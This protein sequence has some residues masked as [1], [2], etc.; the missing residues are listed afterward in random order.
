MITRT[1]RRQKIA[2]PADV[3]S[4][5]RNP[6]VRPVVEYGLWGLG[7]WIASA[8]HQQPIYYI[9]LL[10]VFLNDLRNISEKRKGLLRDVVSGT[11][12]ALLGWALS[13]SV[14]RVLGAVVAI[15]AFLTLVEPAMRR[16]DAW[17]GK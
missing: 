3:V 8:L 17:L 15:I 2:G 7:F 4:V 12:T 9:V 10:I 1:T 5:L 13:D 16:I 11:I 14:S 6:F